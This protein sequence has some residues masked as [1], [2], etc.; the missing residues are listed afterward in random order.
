MR[1][2]FLALILLAAPGGLRAQ[3]AGDVGVGVILGDPTGLSGK[4]WLDDRNALD[5]GLGFSG[6]F[7]LHA[8]Y[9]RH[10]WDLWP[11]P[12]KGKLPAYLGLGA[13]LEASD[14]PEFGIRA[15]GG[16]AYWLPRHPIEVFLEIAPVFRLAPSA[17]VGFD[18]GIG[19]RYYFGRR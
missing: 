15:V 8:D 14:D 12:V 19:L 1:K 6:D 4:Y 9:L 13:R 3:K 11:Q 5:A 17:D 10:I 16:T 18:A 7:A 2:V